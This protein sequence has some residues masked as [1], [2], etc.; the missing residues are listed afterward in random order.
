MGALMNESLEVYAR[1]WEHLS[2]RA[3]VEELPIPE[4]IS[5]QEKV[6]RALV[7]TARRKRK[8]QR[9][10]NQAVRHYRA[11]CRKLEKLLS[12][13]DAL[14]AAGDEFEKIPYRSDLLSDQKKVDALF[15]EC[16]GLLCEGDFETAERKISSIQKG[17]GEINARYA[18]G[19]LIA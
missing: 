8:Y 3:A 14:D 7:E 6:A 16:F 19:L 9:F 10:L 17:V 18:R 2:G 12:V 15:E 13:L 1:W 5:A 4:G 11:A